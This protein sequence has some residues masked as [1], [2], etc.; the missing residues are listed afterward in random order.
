M[1][2]A[3]RGKIQTVTGPIEP[4]DLGV[5]LIHEHLYFD[6]T[7]YYQPPQDEKGERLTDQELSLST[8]GW[9]RNNTMTSRPNLRSYDD[10]V[11]ASEVELYMGLGGRAMVD[12]TINGIEPNPAGLRRIS[13]RTG[14]HVIAGSGYY[15]YPSHPPDMDS[16]TIGDIQEEIVGDLTRGG[17]GTDV[18]SGLIGELGASWPLHPNEEKTFR[19]GARAHLETGAPISVH[20]GHD[21]DSPLSL[22]EL[23]KEEGVQPDRVIMSHIENRYREDLD[24]YRR[25]ADTGC[26]LGFDTYGRDMYFA[27]AGRQHPPDDLRNHIIATLV[28]AGYAESV[29]AAQDCCFQCD[30][31]TYGGNGYGHILENIVPRLEEPEGRREGPP[32]DPGGEPQAGPDVPRSQLITQRRRKRS[33][34]FLVAD[35][36]VLGGRSP[37]STP[38]PPP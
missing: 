2:E 27:G 13:Q 38:P 26:M 31:V 30:L 29:T 10:D 11:I 33:G 6:L 1:I 7:C 32:P 24:R 18:L 3:L 34:D 37:H 20:P 12:C 22:I 16:K 9:V 28:A 35:R 8:L 23:L 4:D 14:L 21:P 25:L 19:A 5:T 36:G 17:H 15:I